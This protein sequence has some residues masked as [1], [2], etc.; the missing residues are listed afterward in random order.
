ME[1]PSPCSW[2]PR[3]CVKERWF[4]ADVG[5]SF[6]VANF[7]FLPEGRP[8]GCISWEGISRDVVIITNSV[9]HVPNRT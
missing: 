4:R 5:E 2:M 8:C 1:S 6:S 7:I 3:E 9:L